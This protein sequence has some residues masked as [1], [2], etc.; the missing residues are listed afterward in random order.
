[1]RLGISG[2][3]E[4]RDIDT[5]QTKSIYWRPGI[6]YIRSSFGLH[7]KNISKHHKEIYSSDNLLQAQKRKPTSFGN[8][9]ANKFNSCSF[10]SKEKKTVR[11]RQFF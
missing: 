8:Q 9:N 3:T 10:C 5:N 6:G 1:M 2:G 11:L 7:I 4:D